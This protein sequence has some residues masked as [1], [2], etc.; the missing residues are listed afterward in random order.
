MK[1]KELEL[2]VIV[3]KGYYKLVKNVQNDKN[4]LRLFPGRQ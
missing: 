4:A 2:N 3:E 1:Q